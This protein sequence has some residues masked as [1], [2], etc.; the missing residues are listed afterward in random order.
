MES[1]QEIAK[2]KVLGKSNRIPCPPGVPLSLNHTFF[3]TQASWENIKHNFEKW[4]LFLFYS[5]RDIT[6]LK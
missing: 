3:L 2:Q 6:W 4:K 1:I 5:N